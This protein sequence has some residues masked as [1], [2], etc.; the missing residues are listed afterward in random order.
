MGLPPPLRGGPI[1]APQR[2]AAL[3]AASWAL[4]EGSWGGAG[5]GAHSWG[6]EQGRKTD[7]Q[8]TGRS[9]HSLGHVS[10]AHLRPQSEGPCPYRCLQAKGPSRPA[11]LYSWP[12]L[13]E[14]PTAAA[15]AVAAVAMGSRS[16]SSSGDSSFSPRSSPSARKQGSE[17]ER[18]EGGRGEEER[19]R[20][21][22]AAGGREEGKC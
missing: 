7:K 20:G 3:P 8:E 18:G 10:P 14:V 12:G 17:G 6:W 11:R 4:R 5:G 22:G 16:W 1:P 21:R 19:R 15:V 13:R 9:H 2:P